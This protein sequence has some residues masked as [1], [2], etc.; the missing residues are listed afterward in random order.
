MRIA[1]IIGMFLALSVVLAHSVFPHHHHVESEEV[2][3][4]EDTDHHHEND[5]DHHHH[6]A[7]NHE[8]SIFTFG[9]IE[10]TFL[11]GKQIIL[12]IIVAPVFEVFEWSFVAYCNKEPDD[13]YIEDIDLPPMRQCQ[14]IS[15][16]GPPVI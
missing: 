4:S 12:P 1:R 16:R 10:S 3:Y 5:S 15:F 11:T 6:K 14:Q 9:Q 8:H 7:D 2:N 13:I